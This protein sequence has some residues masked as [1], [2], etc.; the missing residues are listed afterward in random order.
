[1]ENNFDLIVIGAGPGGYMAALYGAKAG[2]RTALIEKND[3]GGTCLNRGCI[4]TKALLH[5]AKL[6]ED[7]K[8]AK[9]WGISTAEPDYDLGSLYRRKDAVVEQLRNG[10]LSQLKARK[11]TVFHGVGRIEGAHEVS[12]ESIPGAPAE[13]VGGGWADGISGTPAGNAGGKQTLTAKHILI[14]SG[15]VPAMPPIPGIDL[16][17][18]MT[19]DGLL[20]TSK[21]GQWPKDKKRLVIIGGGVIGIEFAAAFCALDFKVTVIEA[22]DRILGNMDR[23]ISQNVKMI[24]K[25]KGVEFYTGATVERIEAGEDGLL[26]HYSQKEQPA[27]AV[28]D[29]ILVAAGRRPAGNGLFAGLAAPQE[30]KGALVVNE[31]YQTAYP[32]IY[33][34]G[35]VIGGV[36]LA[37]AATAQGICAVQHMLGRTPSYDSNTIPSCVYIQPEIASVGITADDAKAA[38]RPVVVKKYPMSANGKSVLT[39]QERGF[40][41]LVADKET[42]QILGAQLMCARATDMIGELGLAIGAGL[43]LKEMGAVIHPHPTYCEGIGEALLE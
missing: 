37:H 35:D 18:V 32:S 22:L 1:M 41:K 16:P 29:H 12:V 20:D 25:K 14:A 36:Q 27:S 28:A 9:T 8:H 23:E 24:Y 34:I 3:I 40:V 33:A 31:N 21:V 15:S 4:P 26:C 13:G 11:V 10:I 5:G 43:T 39:N 19:S 17:G 6:Y 38:G 42:Q 30:N 7:M 2:L